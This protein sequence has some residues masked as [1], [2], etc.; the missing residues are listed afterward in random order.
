[1]PHQFVEAFDNHVAV[2]VD[3][4]EIPIE[5]ASNLQARAQTFSH[6][7]HKNTFKYLIGIAQ[8]GAISFISKGWGGRVSDLTENSGLLQKL[9]PGD[10]VLA[11]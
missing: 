9:L 8:H 3:C 2:I 1:M 5:R 4:F 6:Y 7:K 11:D 10:L